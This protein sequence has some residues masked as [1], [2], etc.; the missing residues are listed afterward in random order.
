MH[1]TTYRGTLVTHQKA[2]LS[3]W[4]EVWFNDKA[5]TTIFG[6][7]EMVDQ[8]QITYNSEKGNAFV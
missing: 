4:G 7:A 2:N 3:Q 6:Y 1:L 8:Y 5:V